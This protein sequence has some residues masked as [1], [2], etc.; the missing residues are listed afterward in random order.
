MGGGRNFERPNVEQPI[1]RNFKNANV[2]SYERSSYS[3]F[4]IYE[5]IVYFF[6]NYFNTQIL[7][8]FFNFNAPNFFNFPNL[9]FFG[10]F[11]FFLIN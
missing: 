6:F 5:I 9:I 4:F 10:F 2:E 8:F 7:F 1:F 3:I 11:K